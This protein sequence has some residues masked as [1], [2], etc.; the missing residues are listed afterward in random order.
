MN[1]KPVKKKNSTPS[2]PEVPQIFAVQMNAGKASFSRRDFLAAAGI[3]ATAAALSGCDVVDTSIANPTTMP[4]ETIPPKNTPT[5]YLTATPAPTLAPDLVD[6]CGRARAHTGRV[7]LLAISMDGSL[8]VSSGDET[9][10][11]WLLPY[12]ALLLTLERGEI[13]PIENLLI[14]PDN[15]YLVAGWNLQLIKVWSLPDG[16]LR[17]T[18]E[19]SGNA[20]AIS[21]DGSTLASGNG[22]KIKLWS[23]A[24]GKLLNTL[25]PI[26]VYAFDL[27]FSPDGAS[28]IVIDRDEIGVLSYPDGALIQK[29]AGGEKNWDATINLDGSRL[30]VDTGKGNGIQIWSLPEGI[31]L[32]TIEVDTDSYSK[33]TISPDGSLLVVGSGLNNQKIERW[34]LPEG[35]RFRSL[36]HSPEG[37]TSL[38]TSP[39]STLLVSGGSD[40]TIKLWSLPYGEP[41]SCPIDLAINNTNVEGVSYEVTNDLGGVRTITLPCG[42]PIP[43]GA[44]CT[45]NC[46]AGGMCSCVG[47]SC[48]CDAHS[49]GVHYWYPN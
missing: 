15:K 28:L 10:K 42:S 19:T 9:I 46:V 47:H 18:L 2:D 27:L 33:P 22:E 32:Q 6:K 5:P 48:T 45:C 24:D 20:T 25:G 38:A 40:G 17:Y 29:L 35:K 16:V 44:V 39:D 43:A 13:L 31:L 8:L 7:E 21:P 12:G 3:A 11:V 30:A 37:H 14:S 41:I 36:M 1:K 26:G 34:S 23:L 49:T 4:S